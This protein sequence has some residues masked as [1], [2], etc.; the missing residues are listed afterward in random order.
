MLTII[1]DLFSVSKFIEYENSQMAA[2]SRYGVLFPSVSN[3]I[4]LPDVCIEVFPCFAI[5]E[6][7]YSTD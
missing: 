5:L 7:S 4:G 3:D 6:C 2:L 1:L